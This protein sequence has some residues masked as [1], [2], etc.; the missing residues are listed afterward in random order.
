MSSY[1]VIDHKM[2]SGMPPTDTKQL[3]PRPALAA[4]AATLPLLHATAGALLSSVNVTQGTQITHDE[5]L[6][7]ALSAVPK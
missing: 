6:K 4:D 5:A 3:P 7:F 1:L 2:G